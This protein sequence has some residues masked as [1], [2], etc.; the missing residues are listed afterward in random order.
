MYVEPL[1]SV[2]FLMSFTVTKMSKGFPT[3]LTHIGLLTNVNS[4][5]SFQGTRTRETFPTLLT[6]I[7]IRTT[8]SY[9]MFLKLIPK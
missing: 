9:F 8:V 2:N 6:N 7:G 4:L 5:V 1:C 3:V